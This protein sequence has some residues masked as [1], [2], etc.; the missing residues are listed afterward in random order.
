MA[1]NPDIIGRGWVFPFRFTTL[2]SVAKIVGMSP[3]DAIAKIQMSIAQILGTKIGSR[4]ID[5]DFGSDLRGLIFT[6]ID[7]LSAARV[8]GAIIDAIQNNE[9]RV[10]ILNVDVSIARAKEGV[11]ETSIDFRVISTQVEGN[12]VYPFMLSPDMRVQGQISIG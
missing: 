7:S 6:P 11:L 4:Y 10:E 2:G 1:T 3:D 5:R 12:L 8:R 9:K